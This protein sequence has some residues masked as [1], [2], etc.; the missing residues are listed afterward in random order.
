MNDIDPNVSVMGAHFFS[1]VGMSLDPILRLQ[2][3]SCK[4]SDPDH[5]NHNNREGNKSFHS[6]LAHEHAYSYSV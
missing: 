4:I 3:F 6:G 1:I 2:V 5:Q